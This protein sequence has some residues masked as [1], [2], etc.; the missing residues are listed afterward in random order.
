MMAEGFVVDGRPLPW[1]SAAVH[2]W[3]SRPDRWESLLDAVAALGFRIIETYVP[4]SVHERAPH[5]YDFGQEDRSR[6]IGRFL[7]L[8]Q[9]RGLFALVRPGPHINSELT[10]FGYPARVLAHPGVQARTAQGT[11]AWFPG[12][13]RPFPIPSY[14]SEVFLDEVAD[15]FAAV[16]PRLVSRV[17]PRG[18]ILAMQVDN[19]LCNFFR[20]SLFDLDYCEGAIAGYQRF[21]LER[22]GDLEGI[23]RAYGSSRSR[24]EAFQPP[25]RFSRHEPLRLQLDWARHQ[26]WALLEALRRI[27]DL[28]RV[29]LPGGVPLFANLPPGTDT[30]PF[31]LNGIERIVDAA[32]MDLYHTRL[33][34]PAVRRAARAL[35]AQT[36]LPACPEFGAGCFFT[37]T[38]TTPEDNRQAALAAMMYGVRAFNFYMVVDRDR[39]YGAPIRADGR[40]R[41]PLAG[42]YQQLLEQVGRHGLE[43]RPRRC[44][45]ALMRV[46]LYDRLHALSSLTHPMPPL[47]LGLLGLKPGQLVRDDASG[48]LAIDHEGAQEAWQGALDAAHVD[49]DL[50]DSEQ[51]LASLSGYKMV[52]VPTL[53]RFDAALAMKLLELAR[54]GCRVVFGPQAPRVDLETGADIGWPHATTAGLGSV[55]SSQA[56][57]R[58]TAV[59]ISCGAG[60]LVQTGAPGEGLE[61]QLEASSAVRT[62]IQGEG[63]GRAHIQGTRLA[64]SGPLPELVWVMNSGPTSGR[65]RVLTPGVL[66]DVFSDER[67]GNPP[68]DTSGEVWF[69]IE[70]ATVRLFAVESRSDRPDEWPLEPSIG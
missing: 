64:A 31:D 13:P 37:W 56:M 21:L 19:E 6:D 15:W 3:R 24:V 7:D 36:R 40:R 9:A 43:A 53:E 49:F 5:H 23:N 14:A 67:V 28:L 61:E 12:F 41:E 26:S 57:T 45:V 8:V 44:E 52:I 16:M 66:R 32:G 58:S 69:T 50:A 70:P 30:S 33:E 18:P 51:D 59:P 39:W 55:T 22:Y 63:A 25:R 11:P 42:F 48:R 29:H 4:W 17:Y 1:M 60:W 68:S 65:A 54:L 34:L 46:R 47:V 38:P 27:R 20:T 35:S 62:G 2:Y 10:D